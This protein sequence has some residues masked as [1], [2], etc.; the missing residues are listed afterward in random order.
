MSQINSP[1][2]TTNGAVEVRF[3]RLSG[4]VINSAGLRPANCKVKAVLTTALGVL[5][6][7][8]EIVRVGRGE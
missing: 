4:I 8:I 6:L 1:N 2:P 5:A 7:V 3:G